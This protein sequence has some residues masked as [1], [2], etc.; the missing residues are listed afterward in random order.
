[1]KIK[2]S[3]RFDKENKKFI[4]HER[5]EKPVK[6]I[7]RTVFFIG[8]ITSVFSF[9]WYI[10]L[11][12]ALVLAG[13]EYTLE[14]TG[15][16]FT[17]LFVQ[18]I[19]DSIDLKKAEWFSNVFGFIKGNAIDKKFLVGLAFRDKEAGEKVFKCISS[20]NNFERVDM[21]NNINISFIIEDS[22]NYSTYIYPSMNREVIKKFHTSM[23]KERNGKEHIKLI[24]TLIM[25][26]KFPYKSSHF[27]K[28]QEEYKNF[29]LFEIG[30]KAQEHKQFSL[31]GF[32]LNNGEFKQLEIL[33]IEKYHL[34][35]KRREDLTREDLEFNY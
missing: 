20:W 19:P 26:R 28:F 18:P 6:W 23:D 33:P 3:I 1:M 7:L 27:S 14:R 9:Q 24:F 21:E 29:S 35:I 25:H 13:I 11:T 34:K 32:Y 8:I 10:S 2:N 31:Q 5:Y 22:D 12:L 17:T 4:L 15:F 30:G 16:M